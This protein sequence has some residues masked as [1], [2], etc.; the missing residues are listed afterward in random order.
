MFSYY[1]RDYTRYLST[2]QSGYA[3]PPP[4]PLQIQLLRGGRNFKFQPAKAPAAGLVSNTRNC[5]CIKSTQTLASA[6]IF[7][8][9]KK[10]KQFNK[11]LFTIETFILILGTASGHLFIYSMVSGVQLSLPVSAIFIFLTI[12]DAYNF[13][14]KKYFKNIFEEYQEG[15]TKFW[16]KSYKMC[17]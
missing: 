10:N 6:G 11:Y 14:G 5:V 15:Y 1:K 4:P 12:Q 9:N 8:K 17:T 2:D 13:V 7:I 3:H 16:L